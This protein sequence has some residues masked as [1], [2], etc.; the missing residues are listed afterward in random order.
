MKWPELHPDGTPPNRKCKAPAKK[1]LSC[2]HFA[3][4]FDQPLPRM[5]WPCLDKDGVQTAKGM[6]GRKDPDSFV[7]WGFL[8]HSAIFHSS[9]QF[10]NF[11][12]FVIV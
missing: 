11:G 7:R 8:L 5:V 3:E 9:I 12:A 10:C 4:N 2:Y 6:A 1:N